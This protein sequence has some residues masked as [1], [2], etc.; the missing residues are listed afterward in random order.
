MNGVLLDCSNK[1]WLVTALQAGAGPNLATVFICSQFM[2]MHNKMINRSIRNS[3][4]CANFA[5]WQYDNSIPPLFQK[6]ISIVD[7]QVSNAKV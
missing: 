3:Y 5:R 2:R 6:K 1:K 4:E 7:W